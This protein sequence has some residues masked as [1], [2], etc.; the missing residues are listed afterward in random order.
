MLNFTCSFPLSGDCVSGWQLYSGGKVSTSVLT[1]Y[2]SIK[3]SRYYLLTE[4]TS[5]RL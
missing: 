3:L 2:P 4:N 5:V 1:I